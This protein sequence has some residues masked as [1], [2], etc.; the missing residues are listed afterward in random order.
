MTYGIWNSNWGHWCH[1]RCN[2]EELKTDDIN[3]AH[4]QLNYLYA[5]HDTTNW[6]K[7][8]FIVKERACSSQ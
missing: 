8:K 1:G 6:L 3:V 5:L 2:W 4:D 7:Q